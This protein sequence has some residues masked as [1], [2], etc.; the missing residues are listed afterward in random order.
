MMCMGD[1]SVFSVSLHRHIQDL[2]VVQVQRGM[3]R[4]KT[5]E[6][7]K[8]ELHHR[9][10]RRIALDTIV[11]ALQVIPMR[12]CAYSILRIWRVWVMFLY[13]SIV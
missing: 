3:D 5:L 9:I 4:K 2:K 8:M 12:L 6:Q 7:E 1:G 10:K 13:T 11:S